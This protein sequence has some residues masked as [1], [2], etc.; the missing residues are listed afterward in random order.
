MN[1]TVVYSK[2]AEADFLSIYRFIA[3]SS[4]YER[5]LNYTA[6]IRAFCLSLE[7]FPERGVSWKH[8]ASGLRVVGF[9]RRVSI[10]FRVTA[11]AVTI[12]RVLYG[13]RDLNRALE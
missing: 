2:R 7:T 5:A 12:L 1:H 3:A 4:G 11:D 9:E 8:L 13:G 10:A 6:R